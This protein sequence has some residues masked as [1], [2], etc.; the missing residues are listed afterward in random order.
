MEALQHLQQCSSSPAIITQ[1]QNWSEEGIWHEA[2]ISMWSQLPASTSTNAHFHA[3]HPHTD[4]AYKGCTT[5][6]LPSMQL[7]LYMLQTINYLTLQ[8]CFTSPDL[9]CKVTCLTCCITEQMWRF[10]P[11]FSSINTF[12]A[13]F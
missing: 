5:L 13:F 1:L 7:L 3:A 12:T 2:T 4:Y 10:I 11:S 6:S 8:C 9:L